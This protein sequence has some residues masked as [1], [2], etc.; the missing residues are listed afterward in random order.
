VHEAASAYHVH[1]TIAEYKG[2]ILVGHTS[3]TY[4]AGPDGKY[5]DEIAYETAPEDI[6]A[7][8]RRTMNETDLT[9]EM[10]KTQ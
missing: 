5:I 10:G 7:R 9:Q 8:I 4:L 1:Y 6:A 2:E 3:S